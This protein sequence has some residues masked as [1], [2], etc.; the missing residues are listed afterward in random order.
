MSTSIILVT[1]GIVLGWFLYCNRVTLR[2]RLAL[3]TAAVSER[4]R[5]K[6]RQHILE[7]VSYEDHLLQR[8]LLRDPFRLYPADL[9]AAARTGAKPWWTQQESVD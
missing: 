1:A 3:N 6:E 7:H 2:E 8:F 5:S 9:V 4:S